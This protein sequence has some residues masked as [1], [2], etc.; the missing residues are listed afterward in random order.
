MTV[1]KVPGTSHYRPEID[2]L[3]AV[4]VIAVVLFHL[5]IKAVQ[6]GFLGVDVF[7]VISGFL[8]TSIMLREHQ[9]GTFSFKE[10]WLRR[11]R[12]ILPVLVTVVIATV[13][14]IRLLMF[15]G[16]HPSFGFHG[17][18]ALFSFANITIWKMS[19]DYWGADADRSPFLHTWSLSVEEQFYLVFPLLVFLILK[20]KPGWLIGFLT[21]LFLG[22]LGTFLYLGATRPEA[23][24]FLLPARAW[25]LAVG[26]IFAVLTRQ[27]PQWFRGRFG[28]V[29]SIIGLALIVGSYFTPAGVSAVFLMPVVGAALVIAFASQGPIFRMLSVRPMVFTGKISYSLYMWHWPVIVI[30]RDLVP[31]PAWTSVGIMIVL[32]LASYYW[33]EKPARASRRLLPLGI[34]FL[35][36]VGGTLG[37]LFSSGV[38]EN[39]GYAPTVWKGEQYDVKPRPETTAF[40]PATIL[41]GAV[42]PIREGGYE[43][44]YR[45]GGMIKNYS[46]GDPQVVLFGDSHASMWCGA[47][48]EICKELRTSVS[49]YVMNGVQP[50]V[51]IP[52]RKKAGG[53]YLSR[54]ERYLYDI[55][56][57]EFIEKWKPKVVVF[58]ARWN[59]YEIE[60][61]RPMFEFLQQ[62][63]PHVLLMEQPPEIPIEG[64]NLTQYL[65]FR[66][67]SPLAEGNQYSAPADE[68]TYE[69]GRALVRKL[70][71]EFPNIRVVPVHDIY[72]GEG[73]GTWM[74]EG[75]RSLYLDDDHLSDFGASKSKPRLK[76]AIGELLKIP[77]IGK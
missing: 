25:E 55:K 46:A 60:K 31:D 77:E 8:I 32:T 40:F 1:S 73:G 7:F 5:K 18:S 10:F 57:L 48:D 33:L 70:A 58:A 56:R 61:A 75:N 20:F 69:E 42:V 35:V 65:H 49:L 17:F 16:E 19:G 39:T 68:R 21:A 22:S 30:C 64:F 28:V 36:A 52:V 11:I 29:P 37:L 41:R 63:V 23:A 74:L 51:E 3:R 47:L 26:S 54:D 76:E 14:A 53:Q 27:Y 13:V 12:R 72:K 24:F 34:A 15:K 43:N 38:Y 62:H 66:G 9:S 44:A 67:K 50:F 59:R 2:G 45:E 4:A 6:G 71:A